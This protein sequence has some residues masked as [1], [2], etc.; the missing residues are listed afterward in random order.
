[1]LSTKKETIRILNNADGNITIDNVTEL[2][3]TSFHDGM[4]IIKAGQSKLIN[5]HIFQLVLVQNFYV[6]IVILKNYNYILLSINI[7]HII[8][9]CMTQSCMIAMT[10][11]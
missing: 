3:V 1:L 5:F 10:G 2:N 9:H 7:H 8:L 11:I 4:A 6:I